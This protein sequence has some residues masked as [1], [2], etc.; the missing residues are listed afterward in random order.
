MALK[1]KSLFL[2]GYRVTVNNRSIDFRAASLGPV[3]QATLKIGYYSL[4]SLGEEIVRALQSA[5]P[6]NQ[7]FFTVDR[8]VAGGLENRTTIAT[9][10]TYLDILFGTGPRAATAVAALIG[11]LGSDYTGAT[12]YTGSNTS[13]TVLI[14]RKIGYSFLS[15]DLFAKVFGN[16][17]IGASGAEETVSFAIQNFW[18]VQFKHEEAADMPAWTSLFNWIMEHKLIEFTPEITSP[19]VFY[20]GRIVSTPSEGKGLG[21]K[22]R[23]MLGDG[24]PNV[25][26][27]GLCTFRVRVS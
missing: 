2:Y 26:D 13:G 22:F 9:A 23:E 12:T 5:D 1:A 11:W 7:Y 3:L 15:P 8:T 4:T 10:G 24:F 19:T 21:Y 6:D 18:Q 20:E 17:N 27:I 16:V 14:P 25:Y